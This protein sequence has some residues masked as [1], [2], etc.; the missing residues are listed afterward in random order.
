MPAISPEL[1]AALNQQVGVE[2]FNEKQYLQMAVLFNNLGFDKIDQYFR[3]QADD[4]R[5]HAMKLFDLL[6]DSGAN[7]EIPAMVPPMIYTSAETAA[8]GSVQLENQTTAQLN[9]L[10]DRASGNGEY[11][12]YKHILELAGEQ[13]EENDRAVKFQAALAAS[14]GNLHFMNEWVG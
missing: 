6:L 14:G 1:A 7:V 2:F 11:H 5:G 9:D 4:E 12:V 10:C 8:L 3:K 13:V